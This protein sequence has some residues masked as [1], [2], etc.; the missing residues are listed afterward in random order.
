M[1]NMNNM[2]FMH[3]MNDLNNMSNNMNNMSNNL[4]NNINAMINFMN[5]MNNNNN[6]NNLN[7]NM[8]YNDMI[9]NINFNMNNI[10][11]N[12]NNIITCM[13][14]L[15]NILLNQQNINNTPINFIKEIINQNIQM[16][17]QISYNNNII[18]LTINNPLF[19]PNQNN[20]NEMNNQIPNSNLLSRQEKK[21]VFHI[22]P[23]NNN[24]TININFETTKG[25]RTIIIAP[26]NIK[27]KDLL[28]SYA[29]NVGINRN[30][31]GKEIMF[32]H[33]GCRININEE[34]DLIA[35]NLEKF[36]NIIVYETNNVI[37][38]NSNFNLKSN[39]INILL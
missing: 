31:L 32:I 23:E 28:L 13:N 9:N 18:N 17:N 20:I 1:N 5:Q 14:N 19:F 12:L 29:Q 27:V 6:F 15:N 22:F 33:N 10:T 35:F 4:N 25:L 30:Y 36:N 39:N 7:N 26:I 8:N 24:R 2:N 38:G 34:K 21:K 3:F 37:G 16:I 11:N